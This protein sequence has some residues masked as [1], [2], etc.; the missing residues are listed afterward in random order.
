[1]M[2]GCCADAEPIAVS[3]QPTM[4]S[5]APLTVLSFVSAVCA[6]RRQVRNAICRAG[7]AQAPGKARIAY[8]KILKYL[9]YALGAVVV[10]LIVAVLIIM[11]TFDPNQYKPQI[12]QQVKDKTGRT[13]EIDGDIKLKLFPKAGAQVGR[14]T[15]SER[16]S[17][18][19]FA[20]VETA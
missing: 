20:G 8:M 3:R 4:P 10:L 2:I 5:N 14:T 13:L 9:L 19:N 16:N 15:L 1:M 18:K 12:V 6:S 7:S 11:F 17:E